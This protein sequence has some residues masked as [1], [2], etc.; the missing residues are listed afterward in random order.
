MVLAMQTGSKTDSPGSVEQAVSPEL[1]SVNATNGNSSFNG[2]MGFGGPGMAE[3]SMDTEAL[4][5]DLVAAMEDS[6]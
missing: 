4:V 5:K 6:E 3:A 1:S 2:N